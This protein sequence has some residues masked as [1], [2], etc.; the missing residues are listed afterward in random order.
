[1]GEIGCTRSTLLY[2]LKK[3]ERKGLIERKIIRGKKYWIL[4]LESW[5]KI[6]AEKL[7]QDLGNL[8]IT[9]SSNYEPLFF[10]TDSEN[11]RLSWECIYSERARDLVVS[12]FQGELESVLR[13]WK[14]EEVRGLL[15]FTT[16]CL[17]LGSSAPKLEGKS[18]R[19]LAVDF[20]FGAHEVLGSNWGIP[21]YAKEWTAEALV[22]ILRERGIPP[23]PERF[24]PREKTREE[25]R[26]DLRRTL[27]ALLEGRELETPP[28]REA[29]KAWV[30]ERLSTFKKCLK[31][32]RRVRFCV[33]I[34]PGY[35]GSK[36]NEIFIAK[37]IEEFFDLLKDT[38]VDWGDRTTQLLALRGYAL[39]AIRRLSKHPSG[40]LPEP[41][42]S[43]EAAFE[44]V[45]GPNSG[46]KDLERFYP[47]ARYPHWW[48]SFLRLLEEALKRSGW[49]GEE[50]DVAPH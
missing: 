48:R 3:L 4:S 45:L 28:E 16:G 39:Q 33:I 13:T 10:L 24:K 23:I 26:E 11:L 42:I 29:L 34:A 50:G 32:I 12:I 27:D 46:P 18:N 40:G 17:L 47:P 6:T 21:E 38:K 5:K 44:Y 2:N 25:R 36:P 37:A 35:F 15:E 41:T 14:E 9:P 30:R 8:P 7:V 49:K 31:T 22:G 20:L 1:L 19:R 43:Q